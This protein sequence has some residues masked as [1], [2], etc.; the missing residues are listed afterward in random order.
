M[1]DDRTARGFGTRP[2]KAATHG[3]TVD[4]GPAAVPTSVGLEDLA[5]AMADFDGAPDAS[6][7]AGIPA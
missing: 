7:R 6:A 1:P 2:I 5:D 4:Q 3:P